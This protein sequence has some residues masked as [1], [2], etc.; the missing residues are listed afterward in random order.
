M[1]FNRTIQLKNPQMHGEDIKELQKS[2]L[3]KGFDCGEIDGYYGKNTVAAVKLFQKANKLDIDGIVGPK[4]FEKLFEE[5]NTQN[6]T[7]KVVCIDVGHGGKDPGTSFDGIKEKDVVL[8]IS[9]EM[10][11]LLEN[12]GIKVIITRD[13]DITL[14]EDTRI[15]IVN[16][17]NADIVISNHLNS[18]KGD[19]CEVFYSATDDQGKVL[20]T[21]ISRSISN[22]LK[23]ANRG[24]KTRL[25]NNGNDYYFMIR[26]TKMTA[27][28]VEYL[29]MDRDSNFRLLKEDY[30]YTVRKFATAVT[31]SIN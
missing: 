2:L 8:D 11:R 13:K 26:R 15:R 19:G 12:K 20:A 25:N 28:I 10:K 22:D 31:N 17:S 16:N 24:A 18:G 4:T 27:L 29:F 5:K 14:D 30:K 23:I 3:K 6:N 9:L 7:F 1:N 21:N